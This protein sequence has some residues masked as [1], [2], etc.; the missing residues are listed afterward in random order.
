MAEEDRLCFLYQFGD[1]IMSLIDCK[2]HVEK[3]PDPKGDRVVV[4]F[5]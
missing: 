4:T 3:K 2:V 5:E 1:G